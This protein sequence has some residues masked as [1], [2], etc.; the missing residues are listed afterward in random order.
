M[1]SK[2]IINNW[3]VLRIIYLSFSLSFSWQCKKHNFVHRTQHLSPF[4]SSQ[5]FAALSREWLLFLCVPLCDLFLSVLWTR[6]RQPVERGGDKTPLFIPKSFEKWKRARCHSGTVM[7]RERWNMLHWMSVYL[8]HWVYLLGGNGVCK[9]EKT[10]ESCT[11]T[12]IL[13]RIAFTLG[14]VTFMR[15]WWKIDLKS[16]LSLLWII[17]N[18]MELKAKSYYGMYR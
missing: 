8:L 17:R 11:H 10:L 4:K 13:S 7:K 1:I 15:H 6:E 12:G 16:V 14:A 18:L 5:Y 2:G 9:E 3:E